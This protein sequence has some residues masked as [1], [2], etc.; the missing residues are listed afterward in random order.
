MNPDTEEDRLESVALRPSIISERLLL[1]LG[2][3]LYYALNDATR[4]DE[5]ELLMDAIGEFTIMASFYGGKTDRI[6]ESLGVDL[7]EAAIYKQISLKEKKSIND[8][9]YKFSEQF[10]TTLEDTKEWIEEN[11]LKNS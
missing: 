5:V 3:S 4:L 2:Y 6:P 8:M 1:D 7:N 10:I 9:Y 11:P